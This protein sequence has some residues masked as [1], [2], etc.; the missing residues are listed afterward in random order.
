MLL[1]LAGSLGDGEREEKFADKAL[2]YLYDGKNLVRPHVNNFLFTFADEGA[3]QSARHFCVQPQRRLIID[4]GAYSVWSRG[5]RVDPGDYIAFCNEIKKIAKCPVTF[6]ALD[7]I[8]G[9][10]ST[11]AEREKA[12]EEGYD[13]WQT[14]T[15][16]GIT[17]LPTFHQYDPPRWLKRIADESDYLAVSHSKSRSVNFDQKAAW[18]R[19]VFKYVGRKK[20][21][22]GLGV[23]STN[24]MKEFPY[25]SVDSTWW[26]QAGKR[27][28]RPSPSAYMSLEQWKQILRRDGE[29]FMQWAREAGGEWEEWARERDSL[30]EQ[31]VEEGLDEY[32]R[33]GLGFGTP[34]V[35][36]DPE[37]NSG[38]YWL[39]TLAMAAE[40]ER[41]AE[42]TKFWRQKG[43]VWDDDV[44]RGAKLLADEPIGVSKEAEG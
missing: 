43:V 7:V 35:D 15:Q 21:V 37:G 38:G 1:Y 25:Y 44:Y 40:V 39:Q 17:C 8:S 9:K 19:G 24:L 29:R 27:S 28:L 5:A 14:M 6:I 31:C 22:H 23:A 13:N 36:P 20:K 26:V 3:Q 33:T 16:E 34:G 11:D 4:S 12:C 10:E 30:G 18:L 32:L 41:E 2:P 42:I